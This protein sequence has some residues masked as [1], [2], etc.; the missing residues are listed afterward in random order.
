VPKSISLNRF[1]GSIK[2]LQI[3]ALEE[4]GADKSEQIIARAGSRLRKRASRA[5][6]S[7]RALAGHGL[8]VGKSWFHRGGNE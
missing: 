5:D 4:P 2:G 6:S 8:R 3:R 7:N 1:L